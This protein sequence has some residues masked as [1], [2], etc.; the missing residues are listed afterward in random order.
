VT[1]V[2]CERPTA[3][4][5]VLVPVPPAR[6]ETVV[7]KPSAS[8]P[9]VTEIMSGRTQLASLMRWHIVMVPPAFMAAATAAMANGMAMAR[10]NDHAKSFT[11]G[12]PTHDALLTAVMSGPKSC[13]YAAAM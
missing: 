3:G 12:R 11:C 1:P 8:T 4:V 10:S 7:D 9:R 2:A 13:I 6:P 5:E